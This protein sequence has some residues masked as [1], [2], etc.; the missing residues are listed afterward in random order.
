MHILFSKFRIFLCIHMGFLKF[1]GRLSKQGQ[2]PLDRGPNLICFNPH[3]RKCGSKNPNNLIH[4]N[5]LRV[6]QLIRSLSYQ[7]WVPLSDLSG[8]FWQ[9]ADRNSRDLFFCYQK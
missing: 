9:L 4:V 2:V 8:L 3:T 5:M 6:A 1:K 7:T